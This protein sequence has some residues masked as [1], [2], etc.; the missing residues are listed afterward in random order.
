MTDKIERGLQAQHIL[1]HPLF[2]ELLAEL[3]TSYIDVWKKAD[4]VEAREDAH[5]YVVL[6]ASLKHDFQSVA[7]TGRLTAQREA[8]LEGRSTTVFAPLRKAN[9]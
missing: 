7:T 2:N 3:E 6:L 8:L 1:E 9:A 5:R 4:T